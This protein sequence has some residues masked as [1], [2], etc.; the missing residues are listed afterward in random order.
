[1]HNI[2]TVWSIESSDMLET[3]NIDIEEYENKYSDKI[4]T[5]KGKWIANIFDDDMWE[6]Y[7]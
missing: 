4:Q 5:T 6:P 2:N 7:E 1:M 3:A